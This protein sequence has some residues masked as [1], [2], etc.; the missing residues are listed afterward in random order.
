MSNLLA[1]GQAL[2]PWVTL[3]GLVIHCVL[4]KKRFVRKDGQ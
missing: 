3:A 4:D 1:I 2:V